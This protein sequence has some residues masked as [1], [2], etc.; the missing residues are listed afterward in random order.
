M[1]KEPSSVTKVAPFLSY[2]FAK[3]YEYY[4]C[5]A[6]VK[7]MKI[8]PLSIFLFCT[9]AL[10]AQTT[11][12]GKD[13]AVFFVASKF[14]NG[15][16]PLPDA[17]A[18]ANLLAA[19]LRDGYGFD[20]R[21]V[22]DANKID[23]L[24]VLGEYKGKKYGSDDQLLLFFSMHG[25]HDM[26]SDKGYLI[27]KNGLYDDPVYETWLSHSQLA[28]IT[29][30]IP[31]RRVLL[32]LDACYSGIFGGSRDKPSAAAWEIGDDCQIRATAAFAGK[33]QTR[34]YVAAGGDQ[35]VPAKSAFA[36]QWHRAL[37]QGYGS[38][39]LLS[40]A[41]LTATLDNFQD[42][43]PVWGD[44]VPST[45]GDFVFVRKSGCAAVSA[46]VKSGASD[47]DKAQ[48]RKAQ[49]SNTLAL[50]RQYL[51]DCSL[52]LY[53]TEAEEAIARLSVVEENKVSEKSN[54]NEK[55]TRSKGNSV[56]NTVAKQNNPSS[57]KASFY[58]VNTQSSSIIWTGYKFTGKHTGN[59]NIKNA[60]LSFNAGL[61]IGGTLEI[62]M[63]S[64]SNT[65][66][67]A[68]FAS[69][70]VAHLKSDDFF[71]VAKYPTAKFV[72][73]SALPQDNYG[74]YKIHGNLTIKD[75]TNEEVFFAKVT[76]SSGTVNAS[77]FIKIDRAKY[78][79]RY[80]SASFFDGLGEKVIYDEFDLQ[81]SLVAKR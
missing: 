48:W 10:L 29:A 41:E 54:P 46:P 81:V 32:S 13:Y 56:K 74:N 58:T 78:D 8:L 53:A 31:C 65:D 1:S 66:L 40:F 22:T 19:D 15:W 28:E 60:S 16:K 52:C 24:R 44:F 50:Y 47:E 4:I 72:I 55:T 59:I 5:E 26:G 37:Q 21:I 12:T 39:G 7:P 70:L 2:C 30:S 71:G 62:D 42:P 14:D 76:E 64:I 17:S 34:K 51:R 27:P 49:S 9:S 38:D 75:K 6:K 36:A 45:F 20:V 67:S 80:G 69:K 61:L 68:D 63:N 11:R 79:V 77:G 43:R 18:E 35:R 33:E 25:Y 73:T 23:I 57:S 3:I